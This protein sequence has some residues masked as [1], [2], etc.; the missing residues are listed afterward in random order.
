MNEVIDF[1]DENQIISEEYK[2]WKK[3]V[4]FLYW[5]CSSYELPTCTQTV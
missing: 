4:P 5:T 1:D 2:I 3:H